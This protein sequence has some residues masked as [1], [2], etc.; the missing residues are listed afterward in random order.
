MGGGSS[1]PSL[2]LLSSA[3]SRKRIKNSINQGATPCKFDVKTAGTRRFKYLGL[4]DTCS[5]PTA[6][7]N[8]SVPR[9]S[10][11]THCTLWK[12]DRSPA[13]R[14]VMMAL[15]AM[16]IDVREVD[17]NLDKGE[18]RSA[19]IT[20]MNPRQ[21]LPI[22]KDKDLVLCDSNAIA[23]Y[24]AARY[25]SAAANMLLPADPAGRALVEQYMHFNSSVLYP[26]YKAASNPILY[27]NV[28]V[29]AMPTFCEIHC[30]YYDMENMLKDRPW[31]NRGNWPSMGDIMLA[32]TASTLHILVPIQKKKYP[33]L[34][35]WLF[36][37]SER[38]FYITANKNG[39]AEFA[40]RINVIESHSI[41][42]E[43]T[44]TQEI[45]KAPTPEPKQMKQQEDQ[46]D[47]NDTV[48]VTEARKSV[49]KPIK[50]KGCTIKVKSKIYQA[51]PT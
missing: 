10:D 30:A 36:R 32:A 8:F 37:M 20:A 27:Q 24:M 40:K 16:N 48:V 15:D 25:G 22:L 1:R 33:K 3:L 5:R 38:N 35:S 26:Q 46:G 47:N 44:Q 19:E 11:R 45:Y 21:T 34:A 23:T 50:Y 4:A 51:G 6:T 13:C 28:R 43:T 42:K 31:F 17:V 29:I 39:L 2:N 7:L 9:I 49:D 18:H 41:L 14:A 12:A